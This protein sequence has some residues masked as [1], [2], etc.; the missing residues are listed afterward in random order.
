[1]VERGY[2]IM[3]HNSLRGLQAEFMEEVCRDVNIEPE[4]QPLG[5]LNMQLIRGGN[6]ARKGRLDVSGVGVHGSQRTFL[7]IRVTHPNCDAYIDKDL[8]QIYTLHEKEKKREYNVRILEVE[9]GSFTPMV[10][11]TTG[12]AG[13]EANKHHNRIA[14]LIAAKK[15]EE[16]SEVISYIRR[17]VSFN[18]L[19]SVLTAIRGVR[20]K[21]NWKADPISSVEF[22]RAS[23]MRYLKGSTELTLNL[24]NA[25]L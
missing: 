3:R 4:L 22:G 24:V 20:G 16:Y 21:R 11:L 19:R 12:G 8:N 18:L 2:T 15:K 17:R 5:E 7:D 1:M 14:Q 13:P 6:K 9:K 25:K 10:F 23:P